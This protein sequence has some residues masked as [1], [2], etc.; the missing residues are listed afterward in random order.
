M[1]DLVVPVAVRRIPTDYLPD[2]GGRILINT[3]PSPKSMHQIESVATCPQLYAWKYASG[4]AGERAGHD[5]LVKGSLLHSGAAHHYIRLQRPDLAERFY[6]P[7]EAID[8]VA[9][10]FGAIGERWRPVI[11]EALRGYLANYTVER[12]TV[13]GV[14]TLVEANIGPYV[15]TM[16]WDL[17]VEDMAGKVWLYDHKTTGRIEN[18]TMARF[19]LSL[20]ALALQ[21]LGRLMYGERFGG[22]RINLVSV[23]P[24]GHFLRASPE[25]APEALAR[26]PRAVVD[27]EETIAR[28]ALREPDNYPRVYSEQVCVTP[29]GRCDGHDLCRWG[30]E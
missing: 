20:Q 21:Y 1:T 24:P 2:G 23:N 13:V 15:R 18:R 8:R 4:P 7:V 12:F 22:V 19:T 28:Y 26:F 6:S 16:R 5:A 3:G 25:P 27:A 10:V 9:A 14:E 30:S 29:Y 11:Q 17:V